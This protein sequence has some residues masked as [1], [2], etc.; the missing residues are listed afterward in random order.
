MLERTIR[1]HG[2]KRKIE[3]SCE[4]MSSANTSSKTNTSS[5]I[6]TTSQAFHIEANGTP[7]SIYL[8]AMQAFGNDIQQRKAFEILAAK[9]VLGYCVEADKN[10]DCQN[11]LTGM[12]RRHFL[13][14]QHL[15][16]EMS[17]SSTPNGQLVMFLTGPGG[18][19]KSE[20]IKELL[21]YSEQF[22]SAIQQPFTKRTILVTA[23]SGVA[24]TLIH[25]QTLHSATFLNKN[26]QNIDKDDKL[27][28]QNC[29]R[30]LVIDE[31]S[32]LSGCEI[33][34]LSK[35]LNWL[36]DNRSGVY[37]GIDII[38]LGDFRQLTPVG[39]KP[40][41]AA[42]V[43]EFSSYIN[44]F[45]SLQGQHRFKDDPTFGDI[46]NRFRNGCPTTHDFITLN[47]RI[48]SY[49]NPL[50]KNARVACK[51]NDE[52]EAVNVATWLQYLT[53]HGEDKAFVIL[54][55]NI[56]IRVEGAANM[57]LKDLTT[58]YSAVGEDDC[59]SHIE[60]KFTPM[61]RC[62]PR[63]PLMLTTNT[64]VGNNLA[65]GTQGFCTG[66]V[67]QDGKQFHSRRINNMLVNCAYASE[68]KYLLWKV[69]NETIQ[70][71]P[72]TYSALRVQFP[73][74]KH[75]ETVDNARFTL[76]LKATQIPL[77]SNNATTGHK[78]QGSS[79]DILYVPSWN[80]TVNWP[81]VVMSRVKTLKGLFLGRPLDAKKDYSVPPSLTAMLE[82][83][84]A[85][86]S[87]QHFNYN[88]LRIPS[89]YESL[90]KLLFHVRNRSF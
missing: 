4:D 30:M 80:Y 46:C 47:E 20:I 1:Q 64:D 82:A 22:C 62:Y 53:E 10:E 58:F 23:C 15:L 32:L 16:Q 44:C 71:E 26:I 41:Y 34:N 60:G 42:P 66:L 79:V 69:N 21:A 63:C 9:F 5:D 75:I 19:G 43:P 33:R 40:I 12:S 35:R 14:C 31:I 49:H 88:K 38:F 77:I 3:N 39:K 25:G 67:F 57:K 81:Y 45:I 55:D 13:R 36:M 50:P 6:S 56:E 89:E 18:S 86:A 51:Q 7:E 48:V 85:R 11:T 17:S 74:P 78:L 54:A 2:R 37:G 90:A 65:N 68:V 52:R 24:A 28:F 73:L 84:S 61:L 70:I 76:H 87:P 59:Q 29:V 72:K 27:K 8:W 83:L